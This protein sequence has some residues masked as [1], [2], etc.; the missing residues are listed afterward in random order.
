MEGSANADTL[1]FC[2]SDPGGTI[3]VTTVLIE[4]FE[5][6]GGASSAATI[7]ALEA[8]TAESGLVVY[9]AQTGRAGWFVFDASDL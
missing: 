5:G 7:A 6:G 9:L 1:W 8:M 2:N 3:G 4:E